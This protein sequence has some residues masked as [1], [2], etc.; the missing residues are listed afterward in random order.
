M[1]RAGAGIAVVPD[2]FAQPDVRSGLL[3]RVLPDWSLPGSVTSVV[4]PGRKLMPTKTRAFI[5]MLQAA[6]Q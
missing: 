5:D 3:R 6:L 2:A 4:F 1:A